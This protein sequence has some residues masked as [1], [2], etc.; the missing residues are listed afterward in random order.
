MYV[1]DLIMME[2]DQ[3]A[4]RRKCAIGPTIVL[5]RESD[6]DVGVGVGRVNYVRLAT[7]G[8]DERGFAR[9][10]GMEWI[11]INFSK[12]SVLHAVSTPLHRTLV[13]QEDDCPEDVTL[14]YPI[15]W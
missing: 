1:M 15:V 14:A 13:L 4:V 5:G 12:G 8:L 3:E 9:K 7:E 6:M 2:R 11:G 10:D